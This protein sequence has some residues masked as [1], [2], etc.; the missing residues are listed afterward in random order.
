MLEARP[1]AVRRREA[2]HKPQGR[3]I[4]LACFESRPAVAFIDTSQVCLPCKARHLKQAVVDRRLQAAQVERTR[5]MRAGARK[6]Y[7]NA[8]D[9]GN[10]KPPQ[11]V[12]LFKKPRSPTMR[13]PY[14]G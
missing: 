4:C 7:Q 8:I 3:T 12:T 11:P 13:G 2:L 5:R 1:L 6:A 14:K 9:N 10:Y